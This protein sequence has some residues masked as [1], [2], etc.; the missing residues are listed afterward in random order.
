M[1]DYFLQAI[2]QLND[3]IQQVEDLFE[4]TSGFDERLLELEAKVA[5]HETRIANLE[6]VADW[7][8]IAAFEQ[9]LI[10]VEQAVEALSSNISIVDSSNN[11]VFT[12]NVAA[13]VQWVYQEIPDVSVGDDERIQAIENRL[14]NFKLLDAGNQPVISGTLEVVSQ[15]LYNYAVEEIHQL[16]QNIAAVEKLTTPIVI[17]DINKNPVFWDVEVGHYVPV[18]MGP[19]VITPVAAVGICVRPTANEYYII[20]AY[21]TSG[22]VKCIWNSSTIGWNI[23]T[24]KPIS[25]Q[26]SAN[27]NETVP[28]STVTYG[29]DQRVTALENS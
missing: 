16:D 3:A 21:A 18:Y 23:E 6:G 29:L 9:R 2:Q 4:S 13:A 26:I 19:L 12:G 14:N 11:V 27:T 20:A 15:W 22:I 25:N 24:L 1:Y 7:E 8:T 10:D 5:A 17:T 28:T